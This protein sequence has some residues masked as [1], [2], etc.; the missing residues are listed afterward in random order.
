M[1]ND[2]QR[3][4]R[5]L[6]ESWGNMVTS[7]KETLIL[8]LKENNF[9]PSE[10]EVIGPLINQYANGE[11][12]DDQIMILIDESETQTKENTER[13]EDLINDCK[14]N[15]VSK[16]PFFNSSN[17]AYLESLFKR[18]QKSI[19]HQTYQKLNQEP[20]NDIYTWLDNLKTELDESTFREAR[21]V[22]DERLDYYLNNKFN[23]KNDL[24][25]EK[26]YDGLQKFEEM[27]KKMGLHAEVQAIK[28]SVREFMDKNIES[29]RIRGSK[30]DSID[31]DPKGEIVG[32]FCRINFK[33]SPNEKT[34]K[35]VSYPVRYGTKGGNTVWVEYEVLQILQQFGFLKKSGA[36]FKFEED[37]L[38]Q[39]E[40]SGI[41][42]VQKQFQGEAKTLDYLSSRKDLVEYYYEHFKNTF[43]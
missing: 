42:D 31:A 25:I 6:L 34:N 13:I 32:H 41:K 15:A 20:L 17:N 40:A 24:T 37:A 1:E 4:I 23:I 12:T 7:P 27:E 26:I 43:A 9:T 35:T 38:S 22:I 36:W 18:K 11:L 39:L 3:S 28:A 14:L 30:G 29:C 10:I 33:K 16:D 8:A 21:E 5:I 2:A 19:I